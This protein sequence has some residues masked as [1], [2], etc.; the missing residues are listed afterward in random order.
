MFVIL[1]CYSGFF[2]RNEMFG[3][4]EILEILEILLLLLLLLGFDFDK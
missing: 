3:N 2:L 1:F 4:L